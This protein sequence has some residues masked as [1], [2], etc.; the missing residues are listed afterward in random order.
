MSVSNF[1]N[2]IEDVVGGLLYKLFSISWMQWFLRAFENSIFNIA[3]SHEMMILILQIF[4]YISAFFTLIT[5]P[6]IYWVKKEF[7]QKG[8]EVHL[9]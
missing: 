6:F 9:S 8:I 2:A 7:D 5:I 3:G 4:V 1:T